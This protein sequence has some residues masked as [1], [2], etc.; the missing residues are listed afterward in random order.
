MK[1]VSTVSNFLLKQQ[2]PITQ[3]NCTAAT[4]LLKDFVYISL[5]VKISYFNIFFLPVIIS[6]TV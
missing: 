4:G 1:F 6:V 5:E 2:C 3:W